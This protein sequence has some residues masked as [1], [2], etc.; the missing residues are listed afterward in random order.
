VCGGEVTSSRML[1]PMAGDLKE[2]DDRN[3][4][5]RVPNVARHDVRKSNPGALGPGAAMGER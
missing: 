1:D 3:R 2:V 4:G 5:R